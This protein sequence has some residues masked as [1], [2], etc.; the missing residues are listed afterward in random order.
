[1]SSF[2][3]LGVDLKKKHE[4]SQHMIYLTHDRSNEIVIQDY[5]IQFHKNI[6]LTFTVELPYFKSMQ[7]FKLSNVNS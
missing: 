3:N 2:E 5:L 7:W 1:M 6:F 4:K